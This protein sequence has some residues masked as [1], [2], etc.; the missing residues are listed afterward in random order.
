MCPAVTDRVTNADMYL[1]TELVILSF[2]DKNCCGSNLAPA[3]CRAFG[4]IGDADRVRFVVRTALL[5]DRIC[6][7]TFPR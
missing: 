5:T 7:F 3:I 2:K 4:N 1:R 6:V